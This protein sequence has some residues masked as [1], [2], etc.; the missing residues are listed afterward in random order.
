MKRVNG[1]LLRLA[2]AGLLNAV[3]SEE[4]SENERKRRELNATFDKLKLRE[5]TQFVVDRSDEFLK[6]PQG[7]AEGE[8]TVA[9]VA[10]TVKLQILPELKPEYFSGAAQYMACWASWGYVTRSDDNRFYV[11][12]SDHLAQGCHINIYEYRPTDDSLRR[13]VDV[14]KLLEWKDDQYT[15]GKVHGQMGIMPDGTLWAATHFG[16]QPDEKWYAAGYRGSWLFS[17]NIHTGE[18]RNWGVPLV[19]NSLPCHTLDARRGMF[20]GTGSARTMLC[21]D[22]NRK[23]V[24]F[25]GYPPNGWVWWER[26]MLCDGATGKF[27]GMDDSQEPHRFLSF[28]PELN[29]FQRYEILVPENPVEKKVGKLRGHTERPAADGWFYWASMNG[30]FF[31]FKPETL[32]GPKVEP[33]GVTWDKGRDTLQLALDPKGRYVYYQ[34]KGYPS[35]VVQYD[36]KT[37][38]KKALCFPD[39]YYFEKYGYWL[40]DQVYGMNISKDGSFLVICQNGTFAGRGTAFGHPAMMIVSIPEEER[41][42]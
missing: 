36:V 38:K 26:S 4:V 32:E 27:W 8:F 31:R 10:P 2:L 24:R 3:F 23:Q 20:L 7:T 35:P 13:V 37:G 34:P 21:W 11:G 29:R 33:L 41:P 15:D 5:Q 19:G 6:P 18:T 22:C 39:D 25:A 42:D 28:D 16:V 30:A 17:Y 1:L 12:A 40:G 14:H 9:K